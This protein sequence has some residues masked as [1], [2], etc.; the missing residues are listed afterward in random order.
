MRRTICIVLIR[1][2]QGAPL[3]ATHRG[4]SGA[5]DREKQRYYV[6]FVWRTLDRGLADRGAY[7]RTQAEAYATWIRSLPVLAPW[8]SML[9]AWGAWSKPVRRVCLSFIL[10]DIFQRPIF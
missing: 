10:L 9:M 8:K 1:R 5:R 3:C 2:G 6:P 7:R 4:Q